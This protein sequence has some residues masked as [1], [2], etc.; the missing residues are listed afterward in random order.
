MKV[1]NIKSNGMSYNEPA[2]NVAGGILT[3]A[4][5][6]YRM[7]H[8]AGEIFNMFPEGDYH[9]GHRFNDNESVSIRICSAITSEAYKYYF[10]K[11]MY[12]IEKHEELLLEGVIKSFVDSLSGSEMDAIILDGMRDCASADHYYTFEK[13]WN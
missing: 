9:N 8:T 13:D 1:E 5:S 4:I 3:T 12:I 6:I 11:E 2:K 10:K 7:R